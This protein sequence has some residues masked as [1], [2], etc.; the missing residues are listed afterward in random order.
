LRSLTLGLAPF[1]IQCAVNANALLAQAEAY[2]LA[3]FVSL[4]FG[5]I[6]PGLFIQ[7]IETLLQSHKVSLVRGSGFRMDHHDP[8][9]G[10]IQNND[11]LLETVSRN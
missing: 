11:D 3:E 8:S 6:G 10:L 1:F 5:A 4:K 2:Y 9:K 7:P